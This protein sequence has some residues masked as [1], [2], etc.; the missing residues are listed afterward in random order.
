[1][2]AAAAGP[3]VRKRKEE[4][5][6]YYGFG[7]DSMLLLPL[8]CGLSSNVT[9]YVNTSRERRKEKDYKMV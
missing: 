1:M 9:G 3:D 4:G 8:A 5:E 2:V 7:A 6:N